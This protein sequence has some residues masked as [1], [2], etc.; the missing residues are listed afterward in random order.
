M[1]LQPA[2]QTVEE[3]PEEGRWDWLGWDWGGEGGVEIQS[4]I[5]PLNAPPLSVHVWDVCVCAIAFIHMAVKSTT[6]CV[7]VQIKVWFKYV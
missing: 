6:M 5:A 3:V 1:R 4:Q 7:Y 2:V